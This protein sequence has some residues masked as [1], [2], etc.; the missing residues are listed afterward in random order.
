MGART[1]TVDLE[2]FRRLCIASGAAAGALQAC[3]IES[4]ARGLPKSASSMREAADEARAA[5]QAAVI[6]MRPD[7]VKA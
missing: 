1:V 2:A 3:A 6:A 4:E 5:V 7:E